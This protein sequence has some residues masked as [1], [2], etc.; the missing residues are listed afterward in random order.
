MLLTIFKSFGLIPDTP[1]SLFLSFFDFCKR[2]YL[3]LNCERRNS[4]DVVYAQ[5]ATLHTN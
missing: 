5:T 1:P 2:K 3:A 4:A